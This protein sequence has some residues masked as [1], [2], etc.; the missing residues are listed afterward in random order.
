MPIHYDKET[1]PVLSP[2]LASIYSKAHL[3]LKIGL[4]SGVVFFFSSS[5]FVFRDKPSDY[6]SFTPF[7]GFI[8]GSLLFIVAMIFGSKAS[9]ASNEIKFFNRAVL[10]YVHNSDEVDD[11]KIHELLIDHK[12]YNKIRNILV[13]T[14]LVSL[15]VPRILIMVFL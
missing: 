12:H 2:S 15:V 4:A 8:L 6:V 13:A 7:F 11:E 3:G 14:I 10:D 1:Q 5:E 9:K